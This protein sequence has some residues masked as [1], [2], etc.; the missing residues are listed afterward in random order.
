MAG[1]HGQ[2]K[3]SSPG[4]QEQEESRTIVAPRFIAS[5]VLQQQCLVS[6]KTGPPQLAF[7]YFPR[8]GKCA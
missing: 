8:L 5:S 4:E 2:Y 1:E 3:G 7:F 6:W